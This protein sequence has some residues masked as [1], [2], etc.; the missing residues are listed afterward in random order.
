MALPPIS[1]SSPPAA[2]MSCYS[3]QCHSM[4]SE[5]SCLRR[6]LPILSPC[7]STHR[8]G[9][10]RHRLYLGAYAVGTCCQFD[11]RLR[12]Q[13]WHYAQL[14]EEAEWV[15]EQLP[16]SVLRC[17]DHGCHVDCMSV[18]F[19]VSHFVLY[20]QWEPQRG[21]MRGRE[22]HCERQRHRRVEQEVQCK[23]CQ[24]L[25]RSWVNSSSHGYGNWWVTCTCRGSEA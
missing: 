19:I 8:S 5:L 17:F 18:N 25:S 14:S 15:A 7:W 1:I 3:F 12:S 21:T 2:S 24:E 4:F 16:Q 6:R 23:S 22:A 11:Q 13:T 9:V 20:M 10:W